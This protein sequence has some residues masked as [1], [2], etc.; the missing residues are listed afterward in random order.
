MNAPLAPHILRALQ[1]VRLDDKYR[2][3][4]GRAFMSGVQALVRLPLMQQARDA[5]LSN[6]IGWPLALS[7]MQFCK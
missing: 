5:A 4:R 3:E 2:L 1:E 7:A 6:P